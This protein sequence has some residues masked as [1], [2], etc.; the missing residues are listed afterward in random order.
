VHVC[1]CIHVHVCV[2]AREQPW[3][4]VLRS[5]PP[6]VFLRQGLSMAYSSGSDPGG[7]ASKPYFPGTGTMA[8]VTTHVFLTRFLEIGPRSHAYTTNTLTSE[9]SLWPL[10]C[11]LFKTLPTPQ[12]PR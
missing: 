7:L 10:K 11:H 2:E 4:L 1:E 3:E 8:H 5:W 9:P 6:L 12:T